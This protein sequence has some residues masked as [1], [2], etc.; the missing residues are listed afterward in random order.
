MAKAEAA[1]ALAVLLSLA[2][3]ARAADTAGAAGFN[4][5]TI[6]AGPRGEAMGEAQT[7]IADD[8][9]APY[10]NPGGLVQLR[11]PELAL[12]HAQHLE[13]VTQQFASCAV[14]FAGSRAIAF[15]LTRLAVSPFDAYDN[16]GTRNGTVSSEDTAVGF[17]AA[18]ALVPGETAPTIGL[19]VGV[20]YVRERL[21]QASVNTVAG[22]VGLWS[23][24][25][26]GWLGGWAR[27]L[28][29]GLAARHLGSGGKFVKEKTKLPATIAFGASMDRKLWGDPLL[30]AI[31]VSRTGTQRLAASFG[32]E[33]WLHRLIGV[34]L[35]LL[36]SGQ[37]GVGLRFGLGLKVRVVQVDYSFAKLGALGNA[38][39]VGLTYRFGLRA[40]A[41][42]RTPAD[43]IAA[44]RDLLRQDRPYE[45]IQE[46]GEALAEDP[47]NDEA[48]TLLREA[49]TQLDKTQESGDAEL[50]KRTKRKLEQEERAPEGNDER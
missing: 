35:G 44:A 13:G 25:W 10:W 5:L 24:G 16:N 27:G 7:S 31:D 29:L 47:A 41:A 40:A 19:G 49:R 38:H 46:L 23:G 3:A 37:E 21:A 39:R 9:Y 32:A 11:H 1:A 43:R 45:A 30:V 20:K 12:S 33:Y 48:L 28:R 6:G 2:P 36:S 42:A 4:F 22:D 18:Q 15:N 17:A 8:A 34:R 14:P 50:M 26:D